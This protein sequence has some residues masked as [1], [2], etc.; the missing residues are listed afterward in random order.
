M[1]G[2]QC[3]KG[4][5]GK[6]CNWLDFTDSSKEALEYVYSGKC[7][8]AFIV[9]KDFSSDMLS[10]LSGEPVNPQIEYYE[11]SKKNAI[12]TKITSKVK[13]RCSSL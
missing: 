13:T 8:A 3:H 5:E 10:F 12:A 6:R 11:N 1:Y 4:T 7:Y 2:R 9:P